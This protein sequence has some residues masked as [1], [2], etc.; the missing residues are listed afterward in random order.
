ML[1]VIARVETAG[2]MHP[3]DT[4]RVL[5]SVL[6]YNSAEHTKITLR[7]LQKQTYPAYDLQLVDNASTDGALAQISEEFPQLQVIALPENRG[8]TGGGNLALEQ[9]STGDYDYV[10]LSNH[11]IEVDERAVEY[12]VE[13]AQQQEQAGVGVY[14]A[15]N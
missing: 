10:I 7:C 14:A 9:A 8:Y 13:T 15:S 5:V 3:I 2:D 6:R 1:D 11:D 12:L 4:P